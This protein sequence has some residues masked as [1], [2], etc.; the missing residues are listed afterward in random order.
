MIYRKIQ[1]LVVLCPAGPA[2]TQAWGRERGKDPSPKGLRKWTVT[3]NMSTSLIHTHTHEAFS[4]KCWI[5]P[6]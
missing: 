2:G 3:E 4:L 5:A 1:P 6:V